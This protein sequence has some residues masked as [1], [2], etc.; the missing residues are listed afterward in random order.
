MSI[1][2][3]K[4]AVYGDYSDANEIVNEKTGEI[5]RYIRFDYVGGKQS[6]PFEA[7]DY[8]TLCEVLEYGRSARILGD[9]LISSGKPRLKM[10]RYEIEG[11]TPDFKPLTDEENYQGCIFSGVGE[12]FE[13]RTYKGRLDG[14]SVFLASVRVMGGVIDFRLP[15]AEMYMQL[16]SKGLFTWTG[17]IISVNRYDKTE[18]GFQLE[19]YKPFQLSKP[20]KPDVSKRET[21]TVG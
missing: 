12:V 8:K 14:I 10:I 20:A 2:H 18:L 1:K 15:G 17:K 4:Y 21:A 19:D 16:P 9:I 13:K 3:F 11:V 6:I 5:S 7:D